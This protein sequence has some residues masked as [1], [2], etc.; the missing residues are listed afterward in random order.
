[1]NMMGKLKNMNMKKKIMKK[2]MIKN[3][4]GY[5]EE[6]EEETKMSFLLQG[7]CSKTGTNVI[8]L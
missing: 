3:K 5:D 1:M 7:L 4:N 6:V 2:M 8:S